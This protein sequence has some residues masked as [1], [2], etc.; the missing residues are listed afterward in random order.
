M[1]EP[2]PAKN[3]KAIASFVLGLVSISSVLIIH[4]PAIIEMFYYLLGIICLAIPLPPIAG[5]VLGVSARK[6][7]RVQKRGLAAAGLLCSALVLV[8]IP[9]MII[10]FMT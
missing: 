8:C 6:D 2:I 5:I 1:E 7:P 9:I 10:I 3:S 4:I